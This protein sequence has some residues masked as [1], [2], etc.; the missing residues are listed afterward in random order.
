MA[1]IF[2]CI[3]GVLLFCLSAVAAPPST[4]TWQ[5]VWSDEFDSGSTPVAPNP[6]YWDYEHGYVRN[7]EWQ[8]YT[9]NL[10]NAYCC[11]GLLHI[12]AHKHPHGTYPVGIYM[13]QDG[14]ISSA[15]LKSRGKVQHKYGW[16]E[17]RAR[18]DTQWGSWPAFWTL[19]CSGEWPDNGECDIM[20]YYQNMLKFNV[21][22]WKKGDARWIAR[23]DSTTVNISSLPTAWENAF[24]VWAMEWTPQQVG[25]YMDG[26][27][28]NRW[29]CSLDS[30]DGSM[31]G[32]QQPHS[33][34]LNQAIGGTAGGDAS[35]VVYPTRYE[36]DWVRWYQDTSQPAALVN[37]DDAAVLYS[38][39][40]GI[41]KGNPGY[42]QDEHFSETTGAAAT[43]SFTGTKVWYYGFRRDD[44]GNA[45]ILL[46]GV[47]VDIVDCY[48]A[49]ADYFVLLYESE[50]LPYGL[51]M[52]TVRVAGTRNRASSGTEVIIDAFG[53]ET[54]VHP[55]AA[56]SGLSATSSS[57]S[58]LLNWDA[59]PEADLDVYNVYRSMVSC[60]PGELLA[61]VSDSFYIDRAVAR[62]VVYGYAVS[63]IDRI[64]N[65]SA[66]SG[67]VFAPEYRGDL[68][69][70]GRVD[71]L[72]L[73]ELSE[74]WQHIYN[75][76]ELENVAA[77]W[78]ASIS[79]WHGT[80]YF[81]DGES[82]DDGN[83]GTVSLPGMED[84]DTRK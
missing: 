52:L 49:A 53:Y 55:P 14:T 33:I 75:L 59:N 7:Q 40:W 16:L 20:E 64:G 84:H 31:E 43:F 36:I 78:L 30:G 25:L 61:T 13:G 57:G 22:W 41:W 73:A 19:G 27:L 34:I 63:A 60:S 24:H 26:T 11:D 71:L 83:S 32:F 76:A 47:L 51:H 81:V 69:I 23:W 54:D 37:D 35:E 77:D 39:T 3:V 82:E 56:P 17:M 42:R 58:I 50:E 70:D 28:Y 46:D 80:T 2:Y 44:L 8:Y 15:S 4:G 9:D 65:E 66:L 1:E 5:L 68:T 29:N 45:E 6:A 72:D 74:G 48:I 10:Q 38:G 67:F 79:S 12:E 18:I 21:A 62:G